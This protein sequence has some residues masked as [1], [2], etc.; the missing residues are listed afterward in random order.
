MPAARPSKNDLD[1]AEL[2]IFYANLT[3]VVIQNKN[4]Y[5]FV[6]TIRV[7]DLEFFPKFILCTGENSFRQCVVNV[8]HVKKITHP[9]RRGSMI[10]FRGGRI[11]CVMEKIK[12]PKNRRQLLFWM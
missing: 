12:L 2:I 1:D 3:T 7:E 9:A 6:A 10:H 8:K 11:H 4:G 5:C